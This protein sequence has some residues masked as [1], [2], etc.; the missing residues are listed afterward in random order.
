VGPSLHSAGLVRPDA[1][2]LADENAGPRKPRSVQGS[3]RGFLF[4]GTSQMVSGLTAKSN[5]GLALARSAH[6]QEP[7]SAL[8][9]MC[10]GFFFWNITGAI[11]LANQPG[12]DQFPPSWLGSASPHSPTS[13]RARHRAA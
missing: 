11:G 10:R 13:P 6:W 9:T 8:A 12:Q 2:L 7:R 1:S 4:F 3:G 5:C